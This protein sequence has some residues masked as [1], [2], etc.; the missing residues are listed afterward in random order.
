MNVGNMLPFFCIRIAWQLLRYLS[1]HIKCKWL[2]K[3]VGFSHAWVVGIVKKYSVYRPAWRLVFGFTIFG[4]P[5]DWVNRPSTCE[6]PP[7]EGEKNWRAK[8]VDEREKH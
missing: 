2:R 5:I 1:A 6:Q 4:F 3:D 7:G 8:R